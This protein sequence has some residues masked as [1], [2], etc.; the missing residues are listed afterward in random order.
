[1]ETQS[2]DTMQNPRPGYHCQDPGGAISGSVLSIM[3]VEIDIKGDM[4]TRTW[5]ELSGLLEKYKAELICHEQKFASACNASL[6][7]PLESIHELKEQLT[8][9]DELLTFTAAPALSRFKLSMLG[10]LPDEIRI[11]EPFIS[12]FLRPFL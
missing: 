8:S 9:K 2:D 1:M 7:M 12:K 11:C 3:K 6:Q 5:S 4:L 10:F